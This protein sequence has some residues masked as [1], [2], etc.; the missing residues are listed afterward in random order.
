M[1]NFVALVGRPNVGKSTLFNRIIGFQ[2][3]ITHAQA[4]TTLDI[5]YA[6]IQVD[7]HHF[8]LADCPGVFEHFSD[9][10][11]QAAQH[12]ALALFQ[13]AK[14]LV[15]V[16]DSTLPPTKEDHDALNWLRKNGLP[17]LVCATKADARAS[18]ENIVLIE[19]F[20]GQQVYPVAAM[21]GGGIADLLQGIK[22]GLGEKANDVSTT[23][24]TPDI[25]VALLGRPNAGKS[26]L[27]NY[28]AGEDRAL[29]TDIAGT[30]RDPMD[31]IRHYDEIDSTIQWIDTAGIRRR[32]KIDDN[33]EYITY[34][35]S[36]K[37]IEQCDIA[38]LLIS[39]EQAAVHRDETIIQYILEQKKALIVVVTKIDLLK[40]PELQ[41]F[42][43]ELQYTLQYARWAPILN[44]SVHEKC[45]L[46][47]LLRT[48]GIVAEQYHRT[49]STQ[50]LNKFLEYFQNLHTAPIVKGKRA[51]MYYGTQVSSAPP[52]FLIFSN[53]PEVFRFSHTRAIENSLREY[54][55]LKGT[56]LVMEYRARS[57][58]RI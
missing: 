1:N 42:Q 13:K 54:F 55:D 17:F 38:V 2:R 5:L 35:R 20:A 15:L 6:D 39:S 27:F 44:I 49:I 24:P 51:K 19:K 57:Q 47:N 45:G 32:S 52:H 16:L 41:K 10:L 36:H 53:D 26:T 37:I 30:T 33:L 9:R 50:K 56:P 22:K 18:E 43:K 25:K 23:L 14:L 4:G 46:D 48:I 11:N 31:T 29:V 12:R 28:L 3:S 34:L 8:T 21:Q 7:G 58:K 40:G